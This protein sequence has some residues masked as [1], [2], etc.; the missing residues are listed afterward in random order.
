MGEHGFHPGAVALALAAA[1]A[2]AAVAVS[3]S[4]GATPR[5]SAEAPA[6]GEAGIRELDLE[7][8]RRRAARDPS[9]ASDR[10]Q[11]ARLYLQRA[12]ET[13]EFRDLERAEASARESL[14]RRRS[15]NGTAYFALAGSLMAQ[16]RFTEALATAE[17][18]LASDPGAAGARALVAEI[19]LELGRYDEAGRNFGMLATRRRDLAVAP[20]LARWEEIRGRP[21]VARALLRDARDRARRA[22]AAPAEQLAWFQLRLGDL[23]LR[24]GRLEEAERELEAG[25]AL[26]PDDH[27][28]LGAAARL[29]LLRGDAARA[30][31][32]GERAVARAPDPATLGLLHDAASALGDS[33]AAGQYSRAMAALALSR[34]GPLHRAWSAFLL[35]HGRETGAVLTR[36]REELASRRDV[37]GWDLYAWALYHAGRPA[38]AADAMQRALAQGTQDAAMEYHS[39]MIRRALGDTAGTRR[40]LEAAL[41]INPRWHHLQPRRA[42]A[43]LD[44]LARDAE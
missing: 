31:V 44:S 32:L 33:A 25:L 41:R 12:R 28:L 14:A 9:A 42:R 10:A 34:P 37:Y 17:T 16:H 38:E 5:V 19:E 4:A 8:Y 6:L 29:A 20:R 7:F 43:V 40:H 11:L 23:A 36:A 21:A 24:H 26:A 30:R 13:G 39:G 3:G 22:H 18:L 15:R 2:A 35:D 27:R 1:V